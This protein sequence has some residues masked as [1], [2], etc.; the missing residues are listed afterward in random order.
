MFTNKVIS[1]IIYE[2]KCI[3]NINIYCIFVLNM[4][5]LGH[6]QYCSNNSVNSVDSEMLLA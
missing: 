1:E 5:L 4:L 3:N 2:K 6:K